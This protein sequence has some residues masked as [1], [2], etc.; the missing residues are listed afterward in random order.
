MMV[1]HRPILCEKHLLAT[2][3]MHW[4]QTCGELEKIFSSA[5]KFSSSPQIINVALVG[6]T[7][8]L[9]SHEHVLHE[10]LPTTALCSPVMVSVADCRS[11]TAMHNASIDLSV[12]TLSCRVECIPMG[13]EHY[14]AV[15]GKPWLT[16]SNPVVNWKLNRVSLVHEGL[17]HVLLGGQRSDIPKYVI[18]AMKDEKAVRPGE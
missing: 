12:A 16:A 18:S 6:D 3:R 2:F 17:T 1:A 10:P 5:V 8:D 14:D 9:A 15:L 7:K 13:L 11:S 4:V